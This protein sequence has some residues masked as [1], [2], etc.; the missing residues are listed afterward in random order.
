MTIQVNGEKR[1]VPD[2]ATVQSLLESLGMGA[3][4]VAC[5]LNL[6]IVKRADFPSTRL[7]EG[8][9]VE[10]VQMIGGG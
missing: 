8:D 5:E 6:N 4:R 3:G 1:Q 7:K 9:S 2:G 10:L